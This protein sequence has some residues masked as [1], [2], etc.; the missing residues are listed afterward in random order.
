MW[1][2]IVGKFRLAA[3]P[4]INHSWQAAFYVNCRGLTTSL[5]FAD[6]GEYEAQFDFVDHALRVS[7][8][9]GRAG[10]I[11]LR[12]MPVA[13]FHEEFVNLLESLDAP[14]SFHDRPNEVPDPV[15]FKQQTEEGAYD[16]AAVENFWGALIAVDRVFKLFRTG[17][18]GKCSPVHLFWGSYDLAVTRF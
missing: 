2:Q 9:D 16:P 8:T 1:S 10:S 18:L 4:W 7:S 5:I 13:T 17:F 3:T 11:N 6:A 14:T 12:P 15:P